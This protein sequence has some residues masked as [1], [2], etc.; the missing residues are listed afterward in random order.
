MKDERV[1]RLLE[2]YALPE[3]SRELDRRVLLA[4]ASWLNHPGPRATI[5]D[6][7]HTLLERLGF[8]Y[9]SW[10]VDLITTTDAEYHVELI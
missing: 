9:V 5:E 7:G 3:P 8:G 1:E 6:L 2:G 10:L 4:G